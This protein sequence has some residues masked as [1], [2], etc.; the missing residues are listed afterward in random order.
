MSKNKKSRKVPRRQLAA[1]LNRA[2]A[3][4]RELAQDKYNMIAVVDAL[5]ESVRNSCEEALASLGR[6]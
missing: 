2:Q 5:F 3:R 6:P 1:E 4:V